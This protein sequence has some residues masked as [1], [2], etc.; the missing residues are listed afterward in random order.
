MSDRQKQELT[1]LLA[2]LSGMNYR[3]YMNGINA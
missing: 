1:E 2:I 3:T